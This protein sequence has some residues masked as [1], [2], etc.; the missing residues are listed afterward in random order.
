MSCGWGWLGFP[1]NTHPSSSRRHTSHHSILHI[2]LFR[3]RVQILEG[4]RVSWSEDLQ[5]CHP[6]FA[7]QF[8]RV[9]WLSICYLFFSFLF[10][11]LNIDLCFVILII[12]NV[13]ILDL[14]KHM[15]VSWCCVDIIWCFRNCWIVLS[16]SRSLLSC[17]KID[18]FLACCGYS[19]EGLK[20]EISSIGILRFE[21]IEWCLERELRIEKPL[22]W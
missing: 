10:S 2:I 13:L 6:G 11:F 20:G 3:I 5:E 4:E 22:I 16:N 1:I 17:E 9:L 14:C 7:R 21:L 8:K 12:F 19:D 18:H 15:L